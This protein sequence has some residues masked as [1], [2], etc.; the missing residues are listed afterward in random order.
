VGNT[1][2]KTVNPA[3]REIASC[4]DLAFEDR[5]GGFPNS[6]F[7]ALLF[8]INRLRSDE[9]LHF[10]AKSH[11]SGAIVQLLCNREPTF[12]HNAPYASFD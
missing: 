8:G 5:G 12:G 9:L 10:W 6:R 2:S 7:H 1:W 3:P 4:F 11:C